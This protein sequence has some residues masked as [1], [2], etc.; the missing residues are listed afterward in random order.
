MRREDEGGGGECFQ[1]SFLGE[2]GKDVRSSDAEDVIQSVP[3]SR[4]MMDVSRDTTRLFTSRLA[5]SVVQKDY[6]QSN[7]KI[8]G[9]GRSEAGPLPP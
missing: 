9:Y 5:N 4:K 2:F 6:N 3:Q 7:K 8:K 1:P